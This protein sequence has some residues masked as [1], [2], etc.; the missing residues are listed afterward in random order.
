MNNPF[1]KFF[2]GRKNPRQEK[3][4]KIQFQTQIDQKLVANLSSPKKLP[5]FR[6]VKYL[7][8]FLSGKESIII[9]SLL[10]IVLISI[11]VLGVNLYWINSSSKAAFGG[12][13]TESLVGS[14]RFINPIL[15]QTNDVDLDL[16]YLMFSGLIKFDPELGLVPDL[17]ENFQ[18]SE[19]HKEYTFKLREDL[20]WDDNEK[21]DSDDVIF[22]IDRIKNPKTKS[23][24][25]FNFSG[26]TVERIDEFSVKFK[27]EKPFA[28]FLESLTFGILPEHIWLDILPENMSLAEYN[29]KPVGNGTYKIKSLTKERSGAIKSLTLIRNELYHGQKPYIEKLTFK[30]YPDFNTAIDAI[31]NKNT[32][33]MS[34]LP[35]QLKEEIFNNRGLHFHQFSLPQYTAIFMNAQVTSP[36]KDKSVRKALAYSLDKQQI[37]DSVYESSASVIDSPLLPGY[38]GYYEDIKKYNFNIEEAKKIL[39]DAGWELTDYTTQDGQEA[40]PFQVR[41]KDDS[42]LEIALTVPNQTEFE[43]TAKQIQKFWQQI[44][45]KTNLEILDANMIQREKIK[46]RD[47]QMLLYG[48]I[49]GTDPDPYPFWHSTQCQHPGLNLSCFRNGKAD[50]LLEEARKT[51]SIE[52]REKKYVEFQDIIVEEMPAIFL[53][54]TTYTYPVS[55]KIKGISTH[56][57]I[58][59][60]H[61][62]SKIS[63]WYIKTDRIWSK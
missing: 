4:K 62:F 19:D 45:V 10:A 39:Q 17:A 31:N 44:G 6:Q 23:P 15:S 51:S 41:K 50:K 63:S 30:F 11:L 49:L 24:I 9:K 29:S 5:S 8:K 18:I 40:Y 22:T 13:Y 61:R 56:Q 32:E 53:F 35:A 43:K 57:I 12:E 7:G 25:I 14:L 34:Y 47:Y 55:K 59:P 48:E 58:I 54:N 3:I 42:Y 2:R 46:N 37:L 52:D 36:L 20:Y 27:L 33:G 26:V 16:S 1:H 60:A 28:P 21:L 38:I